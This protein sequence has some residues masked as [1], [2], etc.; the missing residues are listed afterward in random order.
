MKT[1]PTDVL[2]NLLGLVM[3][4]PPKFDV[5]KLWTPEQKEAAANWGAQEHLYAN[6]NPGKRLPMP[7]F[8]K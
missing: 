4:T 1:I 3:E 5:A 2:I 7:E 8:L 6:D